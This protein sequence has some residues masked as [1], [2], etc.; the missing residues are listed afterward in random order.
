MVGMVKGLMGMGSRE[1]FL[2]DNMVGEKGGHVE[3]ER[4]EIWKEAIE[5][6]ETMV[7]GVNIVNMVN[8]VNIVN[9]VNIVNVDEM[10]KVARRSTNARRPDSDTFFF[11]RLKRPHYGLLH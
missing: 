3:M 11:I 7:M 8:M 1:E 5:G 2:G 4:E 6:E 9:I 10:T